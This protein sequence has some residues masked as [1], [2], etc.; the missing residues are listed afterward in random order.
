MKIMENLQIIQSH[1]NYT[2][3]I[4][5]A[6][7]HFDIN[8]IDNL[9]D[10]SKA[11]QDVKADIEQAIQNVDFNIYSENYSSMIFQKY[12]VLFHGICYA[13][14]HNSSAVKPLRKYN[15]VQKYFDDVL[16]KHYLHIPVL[17]SKEKPTSNDL[18]E[19]WSFRLGYIDQILRLLYENISSIQL[20]IRLHAN[21]FYGSMLPDENKLTSKLEE[22]EKLRRKIS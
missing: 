14:L 21:S 5:L 9:N 18:I 7:K 16:D 2:S 20:V 19:S 15:T 13:Y 1:S 11:F 4:K 6:T 3:G 12:R 10:L 17:A 8:K 22:L